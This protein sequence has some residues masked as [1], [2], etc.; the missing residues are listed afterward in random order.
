MPPGPEKCGLTIDGGLQFVPVV[1]PVVV[2]GTHVVEQHFSGVPRG[3]RLRDVPPH[4]NNTPNETC[5]ERENDQPNDQPRSLASR[6]PGN[7]Q[8]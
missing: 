1:R 3:I 2:V 6:L 8:L 4:I 7:Q 5:A